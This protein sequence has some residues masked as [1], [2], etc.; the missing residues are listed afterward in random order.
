MTTA[1]NIEYRAV[2][3]LSGGLDS[4][5]ATILARKT[6]GSLLALTFDYGQVCAKMEIDHSKKIAE[7]IGIESRVIKFDIYSVMPEIKAGFLIS[8][9]L[10]D[11]EMKYW[12]PNRNGVMIEMAGALAEAIGARYVVIGF[13][14]T[15]AEGFPDN[16][17]EYLDAI[18]NAFRFSTKGRIK[19]VSPTAMMTKSQIVR[20][21]YEMKF[22]LEY[23]YPCYIGK[24]ALCG[25]CPSC[26]K[27]IKALRD[28]GI[29]ERYRGRFE[30]A[31]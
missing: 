19:V 30:N 16:T 12:V 20:A 9:G 27:F 11:D 4:T 21:L 28:I 18:N 2:S 14:A 7:S 5:L 8:G 15:E 10:S 3:L 31:N 22:P 17:G 6:Y 24:E 1:P 23:I 26:A 13:N 29:Y 25:K